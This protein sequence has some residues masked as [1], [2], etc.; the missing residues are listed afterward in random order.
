VNFVAAVRADV[1]VELLVGSLPLQPP[2][3]VHAVALAADQVNVA[4]LLL[5]TALGPALRL[6]VGVGDL[7]ETVEDWTAM[8]RG[9]D[10]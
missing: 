10:R 5:V 4:L 6:T 2:E 7:M 8:P 9:P 3:A 1:A